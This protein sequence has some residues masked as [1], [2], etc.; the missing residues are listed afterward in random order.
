MSIHFY[1]HFK[2]MANFNRIKS[3]SINYLEWKMNLDALNGSLFGIFLSIRW[4]LCP[5]AHECV[6]LCESFIDTKQM[7]NA[8]R[9]SK[10]CPKKG[11]AT[12]YQDQD[13]SNKLSVFV[14]LC[15]PSLPKRLHSFENSNPM[16]N[17]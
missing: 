7:T 9:L 16:L 15:I 17:M 2:W 14:Y 13:E 12:K 1:Y 8:I 10:T 4:H 11:K 6:C 3:F 5:L